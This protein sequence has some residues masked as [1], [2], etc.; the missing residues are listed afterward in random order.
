[1]KIEQEETDMIDFGKIW[2]SPLMTAPALVIQ[3]IR[4]PVNSGHTGSL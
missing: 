2:R 4:E 3:Y 1:M